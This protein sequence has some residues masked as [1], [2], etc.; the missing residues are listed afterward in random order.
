MN[1]PRIT[2]GL[3][4][5]DNAKTLGLAIASVFAQTE[6]SWELLLVDDGSVDGSGALA[7]AV[8]D[9]RV[10]TFRFDQRAGLS[11]RLNFIAEVAQ[12]PLLARMDADDVMHPDRLL[13]QR[14]ALEADPDL[15]LVGSDMVTLDVH[16]APSGRRRSRDLPTDL[17]GVLRRGFLNHPTVMGRRDWFRSHPYAETYPRA[18]DFELWCRVIGTVR[19]LEIPEPLLFY[20]EP[21]PVDL[22]GYRDT[23]R[24]R[25]AITLAY[26]P[27][28]VGRS[29]TWLLVGRTLLQGPIYGLARLGGLERWLVHRRNRRLEPAEAADALSILNRIRQ[30]PIPG[31]VDSVPLT[32]RVRRG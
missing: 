15:D 14:E 17:P 16:G 31:I 19:A 22:P 9:P 24:S 12:A 11:A 26:G 5:G 32:G 1:A 8:D 25:G 10:R 2:I 21:I 7:A 27:G 6:S 13:R 30:V 3:P 23:F 29:N 20:R 28:S 4:F 18:E